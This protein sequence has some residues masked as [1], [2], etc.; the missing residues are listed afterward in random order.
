MSSSSVR[1]FSR[2]SLVVACITV[3]LAS[4]GCA[5]SVT[6]GSPVSPSS[7]LQQQQELAAAL[8][9]QGAPGY[10]TY[11]GETG[12][13]VTVGRPWGLGCAAIVLA[14]Q[15]NVPDRYLVQIQRVVQEARSGGLNIAMWNK[16]HTY[17]PTQFSHP[18]MLPAFFVP[19]SADANASGPDVGRL[20]TGWSTKPIPGVTTSA[21]F[22][23]QGVYYLR[24]LTSDAAIRDVTRYMVALS[25]GIAQSSIPGS[26]IA[27][28]TT[29]DGFTQTDI[30]AMLTM[31]GCRTSS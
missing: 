26:G 25:Q 16:D 4:S 28:H 7:K 21:L 3:G 29:V 2:L 24:H 23:L 19:L 22:R 27:L 1:S 8:A 15:P 13:P 5:V 9:I 14:P 11:T 18:E 31:S 10:F 6:A 30:Q 17:N 20:G 12:T